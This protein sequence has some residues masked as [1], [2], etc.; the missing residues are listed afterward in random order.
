MQRCE[1]S[2]QGRLLVWRREVASVMEELDEIMSDDNKVLTVRI[3]P[4]RLMASSQ[5]WSL[6]TL[7]PPLKLTIWNH[8]K[9]GGMRE[10]IGALSLGH[11]KHRPVSLFG[12]GLCSADNWLC[13]PSFDRSKR[14]WRRKYKYLVYQVLDDNFRGWRGHAKWFPQVGVSQQT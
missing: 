13:H 12:P 2:R 5:Y 10:N 3:S 6:L 9:K 14:R 1:S 4:N 7:R 8:V 11:H